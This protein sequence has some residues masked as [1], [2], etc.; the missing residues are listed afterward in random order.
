[1]NSLKLNRFTKFLFPQEAINWKDRWETLSDMQATKTLK[2]TYW[3]AETKPISMKKP[4]LSELPGKKLLQLVEQSIGCV[5]C[6]SLTSSVSFHACWGRLWW[7]NCI[8]GN[9]LYFKKSVT[10]ILISSPR[11]PTGWWLW[12]LVLS[13]P[14][15]VIW[16]LSGVSKHLFILPESII[17]YN[18]MCS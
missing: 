12:I 13:V 2:I 8:W 1:M 10:H 15:H 18:S 4:R 9:L 17:Q 5:L 6:W 16:Y 3:E 11:K 7:C 14:L